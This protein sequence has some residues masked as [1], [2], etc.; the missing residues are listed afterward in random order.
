MNFRVNKGKRS[1]RGVP[2]GAGAVALAVGA[3]GVANSTLPS[4]EQAES[5]TLTRA[6]ASSCATP[7]AAARA[8]AALAAAEARY[9]MESRGTVIHA[10][11][12]Q[13]AHDSRLIEAL[14]AGNTRLALEAAN[15]Q[16]VRHVVQIRVQ[17]G[18]RVLLDANP[19]SFDVGGSS[20]ALRARNGKSLGQLVITVQDFIGFVKLVHKLN[21]ADVVVRDAAGHTQTS[22]AAAASVTLPSSGCTRVAGRNY[23]VGSFGQTSFNGTPVTVWVLTAA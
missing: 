13:I 12:R 21:S 7:A 1:A 2:I 11:L 14:S 16:L 10:D 22:L 18:S 4:T 5:R 19:T 8:R 6:S 23:V 20:V 15:R 3:L 17:Q 9:R